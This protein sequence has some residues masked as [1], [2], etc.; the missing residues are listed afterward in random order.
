MAPF[1][2]Y[3]KPV[4]DTPKYSLRTISERIN[5]RANV[6]LSIW[7]VGS[8]SFALDPTFLPELKGD[9]DPDILT[10]AEAPLLTLSKEIFMDVA[11]MLG[12]PDLMCLQSIC[13]HID[14]HYSDSVMARKRT[15]DTTKG[16]AS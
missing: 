14:R 13:P 5:N 3:L 15:N 7:E 10:N 16:N 12:L 8:W 9:S 1:W 6:R 4:L 11:D 2:S